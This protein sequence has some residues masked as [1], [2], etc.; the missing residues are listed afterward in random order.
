MQKALKNYVMSAFIINTSNS[1]HGKL[2]IK[3][4]DTAA[5]TAAEQ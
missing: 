2:L 3:A 5:S 1:T 4:T